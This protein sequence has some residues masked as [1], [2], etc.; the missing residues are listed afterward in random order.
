MRTLPIMLA[1][2]LGLA[3]ATPAGAE[4]G[5]SLRS[6]IGAGETFEGG[7]QADRPPVGA[8]PRATMPAPLKRDPE[9]SGKRGKRHD[10][11]PKPG[12]RARTVPPEKRP[13][14]RRDRD[15]RFDRRRVH[16]FFLFPDDDDDDER[17]ILVP[18]PAPTP[19]PPEPEAEAART[20]P[21]PD[22][23]GPAIRRAR[24]AGTDSPVTVGEP[25]P[26]NVPHVT[27]DWRSYGLPEPPAGLVYARVGRDVVLI[28][29]ATRVVE[30][31]VDPAVLAAPEG[32]QAG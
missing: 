15:D 18:V 30:R 6:G 29:P 5:A 28:D 16:P 13:E 12:I 31:R 3:I 20:A 14:N 9:R 23:R 17:V 1:A 24:G 21:P 2:G 27:L 26:G 19:R 8:P 25:L 4:D 32:G 11:P 7:V 22:P 10:P